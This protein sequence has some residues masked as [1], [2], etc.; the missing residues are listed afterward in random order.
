[1]N[2]RETVEDFRKSPHMH[3]QSLAE[4]KRGR[5][6]TRQYMGKRCLKFEL[7]HLLKTNVSLSL[8]HFFFSPQL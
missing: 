3:D 5:F 1:M 2:K 7:C 4:H 6:S 8:L